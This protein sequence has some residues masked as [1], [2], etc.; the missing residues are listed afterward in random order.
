[1]P[2]SCTCSRTRTNVLDLEP[3]SIPRPGNRSFS[4]RGSPG[5]FGNRSGRQRRPHPGREKRIWSLCAVPFIHAAITRLATAFRFYPPDRLLI[6]GIQGIHLDRESSPEEI[7]KDLADGF[8][9]RRG[10]VLSHIMGISPFLLRPAES[11]QGNI[12]DL[13]QSAWFSIWQ[14]NPPSALPVAIEAAAQVFAGNVGIFS[15]LKQ[16]T[17][18]K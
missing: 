10:R 6:L 13:Q 3:L 15:R 2:T 9:Y 8:P 17:P 18:L 16:V 5:C 1:M 7:Q 12:L 11:T 4:I 14:R